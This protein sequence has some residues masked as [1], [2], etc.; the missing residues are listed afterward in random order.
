MI[1]D[2][3]LEEIS[4]EMK[5]L[6][7]ERVEL[8]R[9]GQNPYV[10]CHVR[11]GWVVLGDQQFFRGYCLLLADPVVGHLNNLNQP[12]RAQFLTDMAAVGDALLTQ[13]DAYRVNYE[14]LGNTDPALHAHI[15]PRY[16]TEPE[17]GRR[18]PVW[19]Y[20]RKQRDSRPFDAVRDRPLMKAIGDHLEMN[21]IAQRKHAG[22]SVANEIEWGGKMSYNT[23]TMT[24]AIQLDRMSRVEKLQTMEDIWTDL[25]KIESEVESPVWHEAVLKETDARV[26]AGQERIADWETAKRELRMGSISLTPCFRT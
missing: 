20:D 1:A 15:H 25:S 19:L 24:T 3:E 18:G 11:S 2:V 4:K 7:H 8:A 23:C 26:A 13:T 6:I 21:G 10:I 17:A 9:T 16:M 14:I 12:Q 22:Q 5:T